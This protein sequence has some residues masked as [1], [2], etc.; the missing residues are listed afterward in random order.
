MII[1]VVLI[2]AV[3]AITVGLARG[4]STSRL[5]LRRASLAGFVIAAIGGVLHPESL[6]WI[7]KRIGVGRGTDLLLYVLIV[8]F[9]GYVATRF[10]HD[11]RT[12]ERFATLARR[13]AL[14][15]AEPP[16]VSAAGAEPGAGHPVS[17][18]AATRR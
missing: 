8:A 3:L 12:E 17:G 18:E 16:Q 15:E 10:A 11:R 4:Y 5:A 14:A 13:L 7:A 6:T 2:A 1:Q 9:F